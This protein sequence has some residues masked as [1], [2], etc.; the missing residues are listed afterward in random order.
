[1]TASAV[2]E[3]RVAHVRRDPIEHAF[4]YP[5]AMLL[6]D[7]DE[8]ALL[9]AHPLWS[10]RHAAPGRFRREDHLGDPAVP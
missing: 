3:G 9:D 10:T 6:L 4:S 2:Y 8:L 1:M 5:V 7:L